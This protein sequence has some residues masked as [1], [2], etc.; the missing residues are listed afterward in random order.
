M[1]SI[2]F[3]MGSDPETD[4]DLGN[5]SEKSR[6]CPTNQ[7]FAELEGDSP[8]IPHTIPNHINAL[9]CVE[10]WKHGKQV[11]GSQLFAQSS[12]ELSFFNLSTILALLNDKNRYLKK[13]IMV[14]DVVVVVV[15]VVVVVAAALVV[16][17]EAVVV[18]VVVVV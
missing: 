14:L 17:V 16:A 1:Q 6:K 18:V 5:L 3:F 11:N 15:I 4:L 12:T 13:K 10:P 7:S 8:C 9:A 2:H